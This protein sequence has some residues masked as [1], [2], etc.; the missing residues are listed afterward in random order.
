MNHEP[1]VSTAEACK[2]LNVGHN[3][4]TMIKREM[5][6]EFSRKVFVSEIAKHIKKRRSRR[7]QDRLAATAGTSGGPS[8]KHALNTSSLLTHG[9]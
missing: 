7:H 8:S 2:Q 4:M 1:L 9:H 3:F 5:G 6:L